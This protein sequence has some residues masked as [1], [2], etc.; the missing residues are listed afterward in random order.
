MS[1]YWMEYPFLQSEL[2]LV[3]QFMIDSISDA[4]PLVKEPLLEVIQSGGKMLRPAMVILGAKLGRYKSER[5]IPIAACVELL[6]TATLIHDD[7]I[8][9]SKLRRGVETT[10]SKYSKEVAVLVGDYVFAKTFDLLAGD[11]PA[12]M[13]RHLS[14]SIM[15]ICEGELSQYAHRYNDSL[16]FDQYVEI[17]AGKTAALFSM[18]LFAGAYEAKVN[19]QTQ[20]FLIQ[21]GYCIG[22]MFQIIDD[23]L[24]YLGTAETIGKNVANDIK[25]GDM[26]LPLL[27]AMKN[28]S[29]GALHELVFQSNLTQENIA[30]VGTLVK[31]NQGVA[32]AEEKAREYGQDALKA[33]EK[34]KKSES[35]RLLEKI[36]ASILESP[37]TQTYA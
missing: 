21:A 25:Q 37:K 34:L 4:I 3:K 36:V 31:E 32:L 6:H 13:L 27:F 15:K 23:C 22:M 10:Q 9:E 1:N 18:S 11:Y 7:I 2:E 33:I 35:R 26:T 14:Q 5:I 24:D 8:D 19:N 20:R 12:E 29:S 16:D 30:R 17:I 28:D